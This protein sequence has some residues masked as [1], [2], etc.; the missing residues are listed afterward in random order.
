MLLAIEA[1]SY[2][3]K[4]SLQ[5]HKANFFS[6]GRPL[7]LH[8]RPLVL[9]SIL[10]ALSI[11]SETAFSAESSAVTGS[12]VTSSAVT[13]ESVEKALDVARKSRAESSARIEE[14]VPDFS[15]LA[16]PVT[17]SSSYNVIT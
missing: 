11:S 7:V 15:V 17:K 12:T 5:T 6:H 1:D 4:L 9:M 13:D 14:V 16:F 2:G 8:G 10:L 3:C